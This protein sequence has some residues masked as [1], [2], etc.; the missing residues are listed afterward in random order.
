MT[1]DGHIASISHP[2]LTT[3]TALSRAHRTRNAMCSLPTHS[4][5]IVG[6]RQAILLPWK[7][8]MSSIYLARTSHVTA[9]SRTFCVQKYGST[10]SWDIHW[11]WHG[12]NKFYHSQGNLSYTCIGCIR[13]IYIYMYP[14]WRQNNEY[15]QH[16]HPLTCEAL[17]HIF[18]I[19]CY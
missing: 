11:Q 2:G 3:K 6:D 13:C 1:G 7:S 9:M 16:T 4:W 14:P 10:R 15:P 8:G 17:D 5:P 18:Y 12:I 19:S